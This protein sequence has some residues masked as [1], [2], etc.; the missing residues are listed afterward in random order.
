MGI[1][2]PPCLY[3]LAAPDWVW[4]GR[5]VAGVASTGI[6]SLFTES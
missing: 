4:S 5:D 6:K 2:Q 1:E 3:M